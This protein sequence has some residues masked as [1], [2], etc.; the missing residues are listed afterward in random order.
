MRITIYNQICRG[1]CDNRLIRIICI[2]SSNNLPT[3]NMDRTFCLSIETAAVNFRFQ[4]SRS[5]NI[6]FSSDLS[7]KQNRFIVSV[8]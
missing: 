7:L 1:Q 5:N 2:H 4:S 3:C 8:A 6:Y